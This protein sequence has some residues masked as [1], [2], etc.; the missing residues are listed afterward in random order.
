MPYSDV[1]IKVCVCVCICDCGYIYVC[2]C[3]CIYLYDLARRIPVE[4]PRCLSVYSTCN[5]DWVY[6]P[7]MFT[8]LFF[9][10]L[11][12]QMSPC[13]TLFILS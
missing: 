7:V 3:M 11:V 12:F 8:C 13:I 9:G 4:L 5:S 10:I 6:T 2:V 1:C